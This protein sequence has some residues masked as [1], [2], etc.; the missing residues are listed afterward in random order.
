MKKLLV[1]MTI[2]VLGTGGAF[3]T[4]LANSNAKAVV[5]GYH[6]DAVSG[7]CITDE[8]KCQ[9]T[10]SQACT[11]SENS[12]VRLKDAPISPTMCGEELFKL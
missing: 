12:S 8:Q 7:Q 9:T 6:I 2:I 1:P 10:G 4:K 3:A 5:N 11:W